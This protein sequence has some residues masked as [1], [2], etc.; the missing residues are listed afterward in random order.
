[1]TFVCPGDL[2][3][4][5]GQNF[6]ERAKKK[7]WAPENRR[8]QAVHILIFYDVVNDLGHEMK[9]TPHNSV[10]DV[11][12]LASENGCTVRTG[13]IPLN[14]RAI[15]WCS[16]CI[17]IDNRA[18]KK[19]FPDNFIPFDQSVRS[20]SGFV[21]TRPQGRGRVRAYLFFFP[22]F[23]D[24]YGNIERQIATRSSLSG[25]LFFGAFSRNVSRTVPAFRA[26]TPVN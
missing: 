3:G 20:R 10:P 19:T 11:A 21:E 9:H 17:K 25:A 14:Q 15:S 1:M 8:Q 24:V 7:A 18:A 26:R 6:E 23:V 12:T 16:E 2:S 5:G 22:F 13:S 4:F